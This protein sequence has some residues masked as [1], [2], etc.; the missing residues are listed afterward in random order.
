MNV[1]MDRISSLWLNTGRKLWK[2]NSKKKTISNLKLDIA[3]S[4]IIRRGNILL[5]QSRNKKYQIKNKKNLT[6]TFKF[7]NGSIDISNKYL[8]PFQ[9]RKIKINSSENKKNNN[10]ILSSRSDY[11]TRNYKFKYG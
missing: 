5:T 1:W 6:T 8:T 4:P 2:L 11:K 9:I 10:E 7:F 3:D